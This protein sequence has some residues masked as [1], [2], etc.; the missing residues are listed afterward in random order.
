MHRQPLPKTLEW[1]V[2]SGHH[3]N[4]GSQEHFGLQLCSL[5]SL[6]KR[7]QVGRA[8]LLKHSPDVNLNRIY[9]AMLARHD[10][11][12]RVWTPAPVLE[13]LEVQ[14]EHKHK[15]NGQTGRLCLGLW[16]LHS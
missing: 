14:V 7:L 11:F 8:Y 3:V 10:A 9:V 5:V 12:K 4:S 15:F 2:C 6:Y 1:P 13:Q 16:S